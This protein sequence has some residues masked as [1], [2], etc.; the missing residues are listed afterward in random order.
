MNTLTG[1]RVL[2]TGGASGI[3][4]AISSELAAHGATVFVHY[5]SSKHAVEELQQ[6]VVESGVGEIIPLQADLTKEESVIAFANDVANLTSTL[7][8]LVNNTGDLVERHTLSDIKNDF[9]EQVMAVNVTS[10]MMVTRALLPMLKQAEEGASIVNLSSLAGRKGG[11]GGSLAYSTSKGAVL[12]FSRSLAAE[13]AG[14]GIRVNSVTPGL[15]LGTRFH[16]T[17]TT[18]ESANK[19]ISEIPLKRAGNPLDVARAVAFFASEYNGFITGA[20]LDINGGVYMA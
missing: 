3:G 6:E 11:H 18:D 20:T 10:M 12:T 2:V 9:W 19:T 1:K 4:G 17:H 16:A 13:L 14:D 8:I 15:I 7:D 5:Y